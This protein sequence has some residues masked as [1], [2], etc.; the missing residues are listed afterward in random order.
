[1]KETII[2]KIKW[3]GFI[4]SYF[5]REE[6]KNIVSERPVLVKISIFAWTRKIVGRCCDNI[7]CYILYKCTIV[8]NH[9]WYHDKSEHQ[10]KDDKVQSNQWF[11]EYKVWQHS[12]SKMTWIWKKIIIYFS[13]NWSSVYKYCAVLLIMKDILYIF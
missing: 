4:F 3:K 12:I 1:M 9:L 10:K 11:K 5:T 13:K 7:F 8:Y 6:I 2:T